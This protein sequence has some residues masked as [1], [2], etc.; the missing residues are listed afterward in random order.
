MEDNKTNDKEL[1]M[2]ALKVAV[3]VGLGYWA[4]GPLG[5]VIGLVIVVSKL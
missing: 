4:A 5:A 1:L 3:F 2:K